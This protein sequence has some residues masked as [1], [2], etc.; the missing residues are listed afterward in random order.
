MLDDRQKLRFHPNSPVQAG[1]N[2]APYFVLAL[3]AAVLIWTAQ[4]YWVAD[5]GSRTTAQ[6]PATSSKTAAPVKGD[7]RTLFSAD[8]YPASA[9][10]QGDVGTVQAKL[11]VDATGR[12]SSCAIVR[13]SGHDSLDSATCRILERRAR[14]TPARDAAGKAIASTLVTPPVKWELQ[15]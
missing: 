11:T 14:F 2:P 15:S 1:E 4:Q 7:I 3:V 5:S 10:A 13:S 12:V 9:L 8:D 6:A